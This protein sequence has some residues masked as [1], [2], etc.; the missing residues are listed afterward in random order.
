[1]NRAELIHSAAELEPVTEAAADEFAARCQTLVGLMNERMNARPDLDRL[2]GADNR[3]M[4]QDNHSNHARF[5][6]TI[7]R[8]FDAEELVD[9]ILWVLRA[10]RSHGF[11]LAYWPAQLNAWTEALRDELTPESSAAIIPLYE[12]MLVRMPSF[13]ALAE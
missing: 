9:T 1:M 6:K 11:A 13:V 4:M 7:L 8:H 2:V 10:Y 12:W 5:I 3:S